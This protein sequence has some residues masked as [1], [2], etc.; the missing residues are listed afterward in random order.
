MV[1]KD[2]TL[3][4]GLLSLYARNLRQIVIDEHE[5]RWE[6]AQYKRIPGLSLGKVM[7][8]NSKGVQS[9]VRVAVYQTEID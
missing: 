2:F 4:A 3:Y 1:L 6:P 9:P 7:L 5:W 8:P